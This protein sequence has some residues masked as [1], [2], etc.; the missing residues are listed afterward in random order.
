MAKQFK[1]YLS[2]LQRGYYDQAENEVENDTMQQ[3]VWLEVLNKYNGNE[4]KAKEEYPHFRMEQMCKKLRELSEAEFEKDK[5]RLKSNLD[6][7]E[8]DMYKKD[9]IFD[10][11]LNDE[12][13]FYPPSREPRY[14]KSFKALKNYFY[15]N[16]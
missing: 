5:K 9:C 6:E 14:F 3:E 16:F 12:W 15:E 13:V 11:E 1:G 4:L 10:Q 7:L 2:D 8:N